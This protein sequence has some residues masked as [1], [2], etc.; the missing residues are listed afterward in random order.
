MAA[1]IIATVSFIALLTGV[2]YNF[3]YFYS[4]DLN[5][6]TYLSYKDYLASLAFF[7]APVLVLALVFISLRRWRYFYGVAGLL[8]VCASAP[9]WPEAQ[10]LVAGNP[11]IARF[12]IPA[13]YWL[14]FVTVAY[15]IATILSLI[16]ILNEKN[17]GM[18]VLFGIALI[19]FLILYGNSSY[20]LDV[21]HTN[22]DTLITMGDSDQP[23]RVRV[24]RDIDAGVFFIKEQ[25]PKQIVFASKEQIKSRSKELN[26]K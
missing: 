7:A 4:L 20:Q 26:P 2:L 24:L 8:I 1:A 10:M 23:E 13:K 25:A 18:L 22:F 6:F 12:V 14:S 11:P 16:S 21:T 19:V 9:W 3:G 5:W 17:A 15:L